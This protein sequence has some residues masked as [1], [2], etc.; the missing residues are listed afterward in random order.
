MTTDP[1]VRSSALTVST[2]PSTSLVCTMPAGFAAGDLLLAVYLQR[3]STA[4]ATNPSGWTALASHASGSGRSADAWGKVAAGGE[5]LTI[6][7]PTTDTAAAF[8]LAIEAGTFD[9]VQWIE[10]WATLMALGNDA[11][12][13]LPE[14]ATT[15]DGSLILSFGGIRSASTSGSGLTKPA[16]YTQRGIGFA[17]NDTDGMAVGGASK[18]LATAGASGAD[19]W[20]GGPT[21]SG[22]MVT[23]VVRPDGASGTPA[24]T[25]E[26]YW[27]DATAAAGAGDYVLAAG[28]RDW[29]TASSDY[30]PTS[31]FDEVR[32]WDAGAGQYTPG[33]TVDTDPP[34]QPGAITG[35][36]VGPTAITFTWGP[37][38]DTVGVTGYRIRLNGGSWVTTVDP[39]YPATGLT[40]S[41]GYTPEVQA[42]DA[43]GNWSTTRTGSATTTPAVLDVIAPTTPGQP[44]ASP[45]GASVALAWTA[46]TDAVGVTAYDVHRSATSGFTPSAGT[47]KASPVTNS[48]TES[49]VPNG[50]WY[51]KIIAR[52]AA[53]N[54]S[55]A[56]TQRSCIVAA[57]AATMLMGC[58][59]SNNDHG[60]TENWPGW[61]TYQ[62]SELKQRANQAQAPLFHAYSPGPQVTGSYASVKADTTEFLEDFFFGNAAMT[63][64]SGAGS[65]TPSIRST[66]L[67]FYSSGNENFET[68]K[69]LDM[70]IA[71]ATAVQRGIYDACMTESSP[72]VR[73]FPNAYSTCN[74]TQNQEQSGTVAAYLHPMA[75]YLHCV[76]WS[77]YPPGRGATDT[78]PTYNWPTFLESDRTNLQKGFLT[79]CFYRTAQARAQARIDTGDDTF[80]LSIGCGEVGIAS[81]PD[82]PSTRP[83][84]VVHGLAGA[85]QILADQYAMPMPFACWW[86]NSKAEGGPHNI[87]SDE[88]AGSDHGSAG[89]PNPSTRVAWQNWPS[90]DHRRGGT[91]PSQWAG[92]PKATWKF[93]GT[94]V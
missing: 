20:S 12:P 72:G 3:G 46:S 44:T 4:A 68:G 33:G 14:T 69:F 5:T 38:T 23:F 28:V 49:S 94:Q 59:S 64:G 66:Q 73:K 1:V 74:P 57:V 84:Y 88:G 27:W 19:D 48:Y 55:A 25:C 45:T 77:M 58:S 15:T 71:E 53:G 9:T 60:G 89:T 56:S 41:T 31:G 75:Q 17:D 18:T 29:R 22:P 76:M 51:Y 16:S 39:T 78:D 34:T 81:D 36:V 92:N 11:T 80:Q 85:M 7:K 50:T 42:R 37:S 10:G 47:L 24:V 70:T 21:N 83:Y 32:V 61:R 82:D 43:A 54:S 63:T 35:S 8:L 26:V 86:D 30:L 87:L 2:G 67:V 40:P 62:I 93:T 79:R 13:P 65:S 90:Y 91:H 6:T 52:D